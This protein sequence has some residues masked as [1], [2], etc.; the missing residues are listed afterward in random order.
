[1]KKLSIVGGVVI[2]FII[3]LIVLTNMS[4]DNKNDIYNNPI[5]VKQLEKDLQEKEERFVYFYQTDC[6]HCQSTSPILIPLAE[7]LSMDLKQ[8]N[9]QEEPIGWDKFRIQGTPTVVHYKDGQVV[10]LINGSQEK[11]V[12][13]EWLIQNKQ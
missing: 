13:H 5:S 8:L 1:M 11:E 12:Y 2:A 3:A 6:V 10:D 9:L 7:E 4:E